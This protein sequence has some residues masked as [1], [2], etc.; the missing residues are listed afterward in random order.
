MPEHAL[1]QL[2][3]AER[4]PRRRGLLIRR[5]LVAE[6]SLIPVRATTEQPLRSA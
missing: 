2:R 6:D 1:R 5:A 4:E 3:A